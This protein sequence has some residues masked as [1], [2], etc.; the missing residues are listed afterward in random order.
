VVYGISRRG[1]FACRVCQRL[2]Y[3]SEA[4][5]PIDRLWRKQSK[6]EAKLTGDGDRPTRMH[7]RTFERLCERIGEIEE[8]RD[9]LFVIGAARLLGFCNFEDLLK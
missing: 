2:A 6:L 9:T 8:Q 4:E 5:A 7:Q 3:S 1:N